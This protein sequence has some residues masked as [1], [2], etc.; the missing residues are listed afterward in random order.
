MQA[1]LRLTRL[2]KSRL[3]VSF[4]TLNG[5]INMKRNSP[6]VLQFRGLIT[7]GDKTEEKKKEEEEGKKNK[8]LNFHIGSVKE[9]LFSSAEN[10]KNA[11]VF[12]EDKTSWRDALRNVKFKK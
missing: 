2:P 6:A 4:E 11:K 7:E 1:A 9:K 10:V 3:M 12:T 5:S 8:F